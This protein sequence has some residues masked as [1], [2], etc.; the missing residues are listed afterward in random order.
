MHID[1][2]YGDDDDVMVM[3][4]WW[5]WW[6]CMTIHNICNDSRSRPNLLHDVRTWIIELGQVC[7]EVDGRTMSWLRCSGFGRRFDHDGIDP[8][9]LVSIPDSAGHIIVSRSVSQS[10]GCLINGLKSF[11]KQDQCS[12]LTCL[13][14]REHRLTFVPSTHNV[15]FWFI[16]CKTKPVNYN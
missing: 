13:P 2:R 15:Q 3:M 12:L 5:W 6:W 9:T 1:G 7:T 14:A 8:W 4:V 16:N 11:W 10:G